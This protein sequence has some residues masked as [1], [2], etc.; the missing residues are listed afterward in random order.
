MRRV[1]PCPHLI[2]ITQ[3]D[4]AKLVPTSGACVPLSNPVSSVSQHRLGLTSHMVT[5]IILL[6]VVD[7]VRPRAFLRHPTDGFETG[8][9]LCLL[10]ALFAT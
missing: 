4:P 8:G 9:F 1:S 2:V 7:T 10:I 3:A 5:P 6:D